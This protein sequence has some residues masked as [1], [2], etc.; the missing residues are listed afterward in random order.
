METQLESYL[1]QY[2]NNRVNVLKKYL[3]SALEKENGDISFLESFEG[4]KINNP[5]LKNC[6]FLNDAGLFT[7]NPRQIMRSYTCY[8]IFHLTEVGK[9]L[10]IELKKQEAPLGKLQISAPKISG[11]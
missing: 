10:A 11:L 3:L 2:I 9:R 6:E 5:D 4:S 7:E 1:T 8:R